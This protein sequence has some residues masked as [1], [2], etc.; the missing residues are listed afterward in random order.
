MQK[1]V[2]CTG[3]LVYILFAQTDD[4]PM[5]DI[6]PGIYHSAAVGA[7]STVKIIS[8]P[9]DD[10]ESD[11]LQENLYVQIL[12]EINNAQFSTDN[13]PAQNKYQLLEKC[14]RYY[15]KAKLRSDTLI[16]P[17]PPQKLDRFKE[18]KYVIPEDYFK[19]KNTA[20]LQPQIQLTLYQEKST[21]MINKAYLLSYYR[22]PDIPGNSAQQYRSILQYI[23]NVVRPYTNVGVA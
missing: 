19:N 17:Y 16:I 1:L 10:F 20:Y 8:K 21:V 13:E 15:P 18:I 2:W 22:S 23:Y 3:L 7:D 6:E 4:E 14:R 11:V 9:S 5:Q 12:S